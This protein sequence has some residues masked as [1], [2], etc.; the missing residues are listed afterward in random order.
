MTQVTSGA[1]QCLGFHPAAARPPLLAALSRPLWWS[2]TGLCNKPT[3]ICS[4][5]EGDLLLRS[6]CVRPAGRR[7]GA[8]PRACFRTR[9]DL[10]PGLRYSSKLR[11]RRCR[12]KTEL[13]SREGEAAARRW[14][15]TVPHSTCTPQPA[16]A[17]I[18]LYCPQSFTSAHTQQP[19]SSSPSPTPGSQ[20]ARPVPPAGLCRW[21]VCLPVSAR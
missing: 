3:G 2:G 20:A 21:R 11:K 15:R 9:P 5:L 12:K 7:E 8:A 14:R 16:G 18:T 1:P 19:C 17:P 6:S 13:G 4:R 10:R